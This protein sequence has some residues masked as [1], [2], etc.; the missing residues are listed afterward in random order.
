MKEKEKKPEKGEVAGPKPR[1]IEGQ[2]ERRGLLF[3]T[4]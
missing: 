3:I 2:E 4:D 1:I